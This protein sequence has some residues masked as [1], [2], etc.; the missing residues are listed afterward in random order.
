M[1]LRII[2]VSPGFLVEML[3]LDHCITAASTALPA[4]L[5]RVRS[6]IRSKSTLS[7]FKGKRDETPQPRVGSEQTPNTD[8][9]DGASPI[10]AVCRSPSD[11]LS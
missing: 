1:G 5:V 8:M 10:T 9:Q 6:F 2:P 11:A 4:I 3:A 7:G